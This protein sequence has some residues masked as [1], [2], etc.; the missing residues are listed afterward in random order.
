M[1]KQQ[2]VVAGGGILILVVF[3]FF[4][5][6]VSPIKKSEA[7]GSPQEPA[8]TLDIKAILEVS[9]S[10]LSPTQ[11]EYVSRLENAV[12]RGDVKNQQII[13]YHQLAGFWKDSVQNAFLPSVYYMEEAAK[14][15][16]S[17]KSL[18]F[19]AQLFLSNLRG[20]ENPELRSWMANQSRDLFER[21]EK[22]NPSNDSTIVGL[23]ATYIFGSTGQQPADVMK[24]IQKILEVTRRD[25]MNMYAQLM[26]GLGGIESG[27]Y[28]K[29]IPRLLKVAGHDPANLEAVLSLG[30]AYERTGEKAS[31]KKWYAAAKKQTNNPDL[32][33]AINERL[34]SLK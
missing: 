17:E 31:A 22:L 23:G 27:Q 4:G 29:A 12:V 7:A 1:K 28:D 25:S 16:N 33:N 30:E 18:T 10:K 14:L 26:L 20:Q 3:Y 2:F 13:A 34:E 8:K 6:T 19:A 11:L 32:V 15:E 24:G 9:K 5:N 21:A